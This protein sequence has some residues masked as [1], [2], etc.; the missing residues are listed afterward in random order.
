MWWLRL[1]HTVETQ[2]IKVASGNGFRLFSLLLPVDVAGIASTGDPQGETTESGEKSVHGR[3]GK[4]C[5][6]RVD[7]DLDYCIEVE[8]R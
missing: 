1:V 3:R 2:P 8:T 5:L 7:L 6:E 4:Y